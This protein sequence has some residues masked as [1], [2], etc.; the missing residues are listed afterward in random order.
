MRFPGLWLSYEDIFND[1]GA[2][3]DGF[4]I[5][6]LVGS[7]I[8]RMFGLEY[9]KFDNSLIDNT[10]GISR[11]PPVITVIVPVVWVIILLLLILLRTY[12]TH[13]ILVITVILTRLSISNRR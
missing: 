11:L 13:D 5:C 7:F 12:I 4:L 9:V 3:V 10:D 8:F 1:I 2:V 6:R